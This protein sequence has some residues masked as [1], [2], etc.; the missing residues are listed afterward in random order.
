MAAALP[1]IADRGP[2]GN[3]IADVLAAI[4]LARRLDPILNV[5]VEIAAGAEPPRPGPLAGLPVA[6]KDL[7]D[8]AGRAP[9]LGLAAAPGP[10]PAATAP[11]LA[12]LLEAGAGLV[13]YTSMTPLAYEPSGGNGERGRTANPWSAEHICGGSSSGSA[14]AVAAG[15]VPVALGSDTAG[16]LRIPAHCCGVTAWKPTNGLVPVEGTMPLAPTLDTIGFLARSATDLLRVADLFVAPEADAP[17]IRSVAVAQDLIPSLDPAIAAALMRVAAVLREADLAVLAT[18]VAPL[19]AACD[20]P[21]LDL[22][23]GEA[24]RVHREAIAGGG[25]DPTLAA[26]LSKGAAIGEDRLSAARAE[27]AA[28]GDAALGLAFGGADAILLPVMRIPTPTVATCEP[29]MPGFSARTLYA[30]S[31]LTRF[32]NGLGL[33]VVAVPAGVDGDGLPIAVQIVGRRGMDRRLLDLA[34]T[35]QRATDWHAR[36][37]TSIMAA[38]QPDTAR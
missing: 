26:R 32:A 29:G 8:D 25:L 2:A 21:V 1:R 30:L 4:A 38:T 28:L 14:A 35:L 7:V 24:A 18:D 15:I 6:V 3:G 16:S 36:T 9:T 19:I 12:R 17:P 31:A 5:F 22:L 11:V 37:P 33:P 10:A 23:Q 34:A 20:A 13:G 27:L